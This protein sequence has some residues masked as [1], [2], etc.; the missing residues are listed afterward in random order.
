LRGGATLGQA[1]AA[2]K[3]EDFDPGSHLIG[4]VEAGAISRFH[5]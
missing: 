4:L 3:D 2:M 1:H 5:V